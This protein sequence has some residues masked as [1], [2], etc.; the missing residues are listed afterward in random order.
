[1]NGKIAVI[2]RLREAFGV[3][4]LEAK[5]IADGEYKLPDVIDVPSFSDNGMTM[6]SFERVRE[7]ENAGRE[8]MRI[9]RATQD[10]LDMYYESRRQMEKLRKLHTSIGMR[11]DAAEDTNMMTRNRILGR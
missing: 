4:L 6:M 7:L 10:D 3:G 11:L 2:K 5:R 9:V 1:M 8:Q